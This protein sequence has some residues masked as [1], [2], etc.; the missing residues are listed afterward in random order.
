MSSPE[1][2]VGFERTLYSGG[3]WQVCKDHWLA[4][5]LCD[6]VAYMRTAGRNSEMQLNAVALVPPNVSVSILASTLGMVTLRVM[7]LQMNSMAGFLTALERLCLESDVAKRCSP[8]FQV[9]PSHPLASRL[10]AVCQA[11]SGATLHN[12]LG[13][14]QAFSEAVAPFLAEAI[15]QQDTTTDNAKAK[16]RQII[17]QMPESELA[18]LTITNLAQRMNCCERH[19]SR[20]FRELCGCSYR[21]YVSEARLK[22]A[23]ELLRNPKL[24]IIHIALESGHS[25][26]AFFNDLFKRRFGVTPSEWRQ[27]HTQREVPQG[28]RRTGA[29]PAPRQL[30]MP[31][32]VALEGSIAGKPGLRKQLQQL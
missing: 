20:L 12:R 6:G 17:H 26:L 11:G 14:L 28:R 3:E 23:C 30:P 13:F 7:G 10:P 18:N 24:K 15:T 16:L 1:H 5:Q 22:R 27:R 8:F 2:L 19:A 29:W 25:S 32:A 31:A 21:S 4:L 9:L